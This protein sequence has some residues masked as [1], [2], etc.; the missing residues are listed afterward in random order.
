MRIL[1]VMD[2]FIKVPPAHY[3][4]IERV[5]ADLAESLHAR[6]HHVS[7]WAGPGSQASAD[8]RPFGQ[9]GEWNRWSNV[10]TCPLYSKPSNS[11]TQQASSGLPSR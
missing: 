1:L 6:G 9:V 5:I 8:V 11:S 2:P 10:R 7:L 4:G 3:G